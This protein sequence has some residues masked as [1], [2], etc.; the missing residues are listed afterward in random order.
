MFL[1]STGYIILFI[2]LMTVV[3]QLIHYESFKW[4][5]IGLGALFMIF[6]GVFHWMDK[7]GKFY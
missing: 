3:W 1:R 4:V 7:K 2:V 5:W 6:L